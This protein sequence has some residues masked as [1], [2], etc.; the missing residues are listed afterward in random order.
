MKKW[1]FLFIFI[2][3]SAWARVCT[4]Q[5]IQNLDTARFGEAYSSY[6]L[7]SQINLVAPFLAYLP[8]LDSTSQENNG[9]QAV[10]FIG[11]GGWF[12][13]AYKNFYPSSC[14]D[15]REGHGSYYQPKREEVLE[16]HHQQKD[17]FWK[18]YTWS[19]LWMAGVML[20]SNYS[21]RKTAAGAVLAIPWL[22][23]FSRNWSS[24]AEDQELQISVL[25]K[26]ENHQWVL[27]PNLIFT[28]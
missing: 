18:A 9:F 7:M 20:T 23:S 8:R 5:E 25:P 11:L 13:Y 15:L 17:F 27:E 4:L 19:A 3:H 6:P 2:S 22:F 26:F 16:F 10:T 21:E 1:T 12:Y 14:Q 28:F 24:F